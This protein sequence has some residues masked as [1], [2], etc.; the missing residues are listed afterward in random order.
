M[1]Q[2]WNPALYQMQSGW[3]ALHLDG[4]EGKKL[5]L[6][7]VEEWRDA[8]RLQDE[9]LVQQALQKR[10]DLY[11]YVLAVHNLTKA[12]KAIQKHYASY[13]KDPTFGVPYGRVQKALAAFNKAVPDVGDLRDFLE[14]FEDYD[15]RAGDLQVE[16]QVPND[17][18]GQAEDYWYAPADPGLEILG[19]R[20][21]VSNTTPAAMRLA[22]M[23]LREGQN[24]PDWLPPRD[25][26]RRKRPDQQRHESRR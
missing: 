19:K 18:M 15:H 16:R 9:R 21:K 20:L 13:Q 22:D 25:P 1:R 2:G 11:L 17:R 6:R 8:V 12:V 10:A 24:L 5:L 7:R 4:A 14:H 23:V 3:T 26:P